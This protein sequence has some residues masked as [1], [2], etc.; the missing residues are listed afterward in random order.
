MLNIM[1]TKTQVRSIGLYVCFRYANRA[2]IDH[3][4][5]LE[6]AV[7]DDLGMPRRRDPDALPPNNAVERILNILYHGIFSLGGGN[8]L[9]AMK[10]GLLTGRPCLKVPVEKYSPYVTV[11]LCI[12]SFLKSTASFAYG[13]IPSLHQPSQLLTMFFWFLRQPFRLGNVRL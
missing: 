4:Q 12:P 8:M 11:I 9:F 2:V 13:M 10:A 3:I 7:M 6:P 5:G 1:T